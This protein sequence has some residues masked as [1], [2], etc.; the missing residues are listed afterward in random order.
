MHSIV[1]AVRWPVRLFGGALLVLIVGLGV[2]HAGEHET[3]HGVHKKH[4]LG[5]FIGVTHVEEH[6]EDEYL[7]TLGI[8]YGYFVNPRVEVGVVVERAVREDDSTLVIAFVSYRPYKGFFVGAGL[9]RKDPGP[10]R[11]NTVRLSIGYDFEIGHDWSLEP[12]LHWDIIEDTENE[13]VLGVAIIRR[14]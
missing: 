14:F 11:E 6:G 13:E 10:D 9:G 5:V 4:G 3:E 2:L 8:E 1:L 12:Q 7:E